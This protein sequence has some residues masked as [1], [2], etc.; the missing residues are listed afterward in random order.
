MSDTCPYCGDG[1]EC[2]GTNNH[3]EC[4]EALMERLRQ[5]RE[6]SGRLALRVIALTLELRD[7]KRT[8]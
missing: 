6:T 5:S 1:P 7:A 3:I 4:V 2:V 8:S